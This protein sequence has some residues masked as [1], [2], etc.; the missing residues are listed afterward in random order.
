MI[1]LIPAYEPGEKMIQLI[2][3][4]ERYCD[5]KILI[6]DDGSGESYAPVFNK[7]EEMGCTVVR[8]AVNKGKGEA[9]KT[10]FRY[11]IE[12]GEEEGVVCADCDGQHTAE[13][14]CKVASEVQKDRKTAVLGSR[15]FNGAV[16]LRSRLGNYTAAK[17]FSFCAGYEV[18]D[19]QTGLRG[20]PAG[21][22][23]WL[24]RVDGSR[25]EY[26]MNILFKMKPSGYLV[27][28]TVIKTIYDDRNKSSHFRTFRDTFLVLKPVAR[29]MA[30][31][32]LSGLLDFGLLLAFE[33]LFGRLMPAVILSRGI[34]SIFNYSCNR[35]FVFKG[36]QK[37]MESA[38]RYFILVFVNML[39]NYVI[40]NFI[41]Y[42]TGLPLA[43]AKIIAEILQF[44]FSYTI[45]K[46]FVFAT[47]R[48]NERETNRSRFPGSVGN[49]R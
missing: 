7:A 44:M 23:P 25:F 49:K 28:E 48:V 9:L 17:M 36:K 21:M 8:H 1:I 45:Q 3:N 10:G 47:E 6:V 38:P 39:L 24:C 40:L 41:L 27:R 12:T 30:S 43:L 2:M 34:S 19:T 11:I 22:L 32:A 14:I 42:A 33:R 26:E 31:S 15:K 13:D 20:Y 5:M 18:H 46:K 16:P 37:T 4:I 29:F 35:Y